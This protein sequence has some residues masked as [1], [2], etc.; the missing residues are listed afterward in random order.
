MYTF[1]VAAVD[2]NGGWHAMVLENVEEI[3]DNKRSKGFEIGDHKLIFKNTY[4]S[5]EYGKERKFTMNAKGEKSPDDFYY[6]H[7]Y[8][9][10]D[11][12]ADCTCRK[13]WDCKCR[14]SCGDSDDDS[15]I[16]NLSNHASADYFPSPFGL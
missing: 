15:S 16:N 10:L 14:E 12:I 1:K 5:E 9:N 8:V 7:I 13:G 11:H 6:V 3:T 4:D 2:F